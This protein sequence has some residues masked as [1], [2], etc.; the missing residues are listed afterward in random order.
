VQWDASD[1]PSGVYLYHL[2]VD[3]AVVASKKMMLVK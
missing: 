1:L 2:Q 3:G